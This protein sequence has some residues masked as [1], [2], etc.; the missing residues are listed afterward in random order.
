MTRLT[1]LLA[2]GLALAALPAAAAEDPAALKAEAA[3]ITQKFAA[4]MKGELESAMQAGGPVQ[5][6]TVCNEKAPSIA[7]DHARQ[8]GWEVGRTSLKLRQAGN[9]PDPWEAKVLAEFE[10]RKAAGEPADGLVKAEVVDGRYRFMKAIP[11]AEICTTCHGR[12]LKPE[13]AARLEKLYPA[14][15]ATGFKPGDLRGAFT[16]AKKM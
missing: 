8:S 13:V 4:A 7:R 2:A 16:L 6:I 15:Q 14:D 9:A 3:A 1:A 10:T 5:A 11:T 12:D